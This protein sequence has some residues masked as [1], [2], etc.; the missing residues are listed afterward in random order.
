[1]LISAEVALY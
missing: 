1:M